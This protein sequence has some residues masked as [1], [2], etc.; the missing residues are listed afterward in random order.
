MKLKKIIPLMS[1]F[2]SLSLTSCIR[3]F[4]FDDDSNFALDN[5]KS[6]IMC[7]EYGKKENIKKLFAPSIIKKVEN[8]DEQIDALFEY[9]KGEDATIISDGCGLSG[10]DIGDFNVSIYVI[11]FSYYVKTSECTYSVNIVWCREDAT[12][13]NNEGMW[14]LWLDA[15][16]NKEDEKYV[17]SWE[18]YEVGITLM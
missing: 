15:F 17:G 9:W 16:I 12:D 14:F 13:K 2:M 10:D 7:L 3:G 6:I 1:I 11:D 8:I 18:K 4:I 5:L